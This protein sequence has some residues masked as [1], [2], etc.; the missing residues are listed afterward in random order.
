MNCEICRQTR[1]NP[2]GS[3]GGVDAPGVCN[4]CRNAAIRGLALEEGNGVEVMLN[5]ISFK[6]VSG[7]K[8]ERGYTKLVVTV[9]GLVKL[10]ASMFPMSLIVVG[11]R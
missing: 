9:P 5:S 1:I 10:D 7:K 11:L 2:D 6:A 3:P 4:R 8:S